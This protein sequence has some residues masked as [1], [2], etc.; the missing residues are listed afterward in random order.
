[1]LSRGLSHGGIWQNGWRPGTSLPG[2]P[3][4]LAYASLDDGWEEA[5]A[6]SPLRVVLELAE[7]HFHLILLVK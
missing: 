2:L 6:S 5:G 7:Y 1:M 4:W 3:T